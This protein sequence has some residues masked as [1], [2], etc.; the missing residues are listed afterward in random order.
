LWVGLGLLTGVGDDGVETRDEG[1][2]GSGLE[3]SDDLAAPRFFD[4]L[5]VL[6]MGAEPVVREMKALVSPPTAAVGEPASPRSPPARTM[7]VAQRSASGRKAQ[8]FMARPQETLPSGA[9]ERSGA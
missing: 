6:R 3:D 5:G 8:T 1:A 4:R 2:D 7:S 9:R